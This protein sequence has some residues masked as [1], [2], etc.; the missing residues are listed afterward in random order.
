[1]R[2]RRLLPG[3]SFLA[4]TALVVAGWALVV[5]LA[6]PPAFILPSPLRVLSAFAERPGYFLTAMASTAGGILAGLM[7]AVAAGLAAALIMA[8]YPVARRLGLPFLLL[9]QALPVFAIAPLLVVWLG[10]GMASKAVM[11]AL[12][13]LFPLASNFLDGLMRTPRG[14]IDL[15]RL[16]GAGETQ[17]LFL[18]RVPA[19]FREAVSGLRIAVGVA[20]IGAIVGEWVGA[21]QGLG[22]VMIHANARMQTDAVFVALALLTLLVLALRFSFDS[23][24]RRWLPGP[25]ASTDPFLSRT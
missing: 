10:F 6:D 1:M 5:L 8:R 25:S 7:L 2:E 23:L 20:P 18:I 16:A 24:V 15:G 17:L 11:A 21:S 3:L 13:I 12:I 19:A 4:A 14:L 22:A 9:T